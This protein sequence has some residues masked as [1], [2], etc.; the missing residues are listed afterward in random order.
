MVAQMRPIMEIVRLEEDYDCGTFGVLLI[1]KRIL[2]WTLEPRDEENA[3]SVSS[4]PAQQYVCKRTHSPKY[5]DT[6][7]ILDVP[8]RT[9]VLFHWGNWA[10]NTLGC[11][12]LGGA[13]GILPHCKHRGLINSRS[14]FDDFMIKLKGHDECHLTISEAY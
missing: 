14:A 13:I 10:K 2:C 6:F 8:S 9:D 4:I 11:I 1:Q 7:E 3:P 5:G 12:I